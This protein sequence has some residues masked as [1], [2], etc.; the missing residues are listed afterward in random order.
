[1]RESRAGWADVE[2]VQEYAVSVFDDG[3]E[4][5]AHRPNAWRVV[6]TW[7]GKSEVRN[8]HDASTISSISTWKLRPV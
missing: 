5:H 4:A 3:N 8:V 1:M 6:R 2:D 7:R